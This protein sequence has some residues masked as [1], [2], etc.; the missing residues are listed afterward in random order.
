[1]FGLQYGDQKSPALFV[2]WEWSLPVIH[3]FYRAWPVMAKVIGVQTVL[4]V[5]FAQRLGMPQI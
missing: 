3:N 1:V 5:F 2:E 4:L